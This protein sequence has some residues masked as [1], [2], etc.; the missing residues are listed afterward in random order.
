MTVRKIRTEFYFVNMV[1]AGDTDGLPGYCAETVAVTVSAFLC[2]LRAP[3]NFVY[4][5]L[6]VGT[7]W[8]AP[9]HIVGIV[10]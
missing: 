1:A 7:G 8:F 9:S 10:S 3:G 6:S 4:M 2:H 5:L